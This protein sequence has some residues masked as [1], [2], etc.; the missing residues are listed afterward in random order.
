[1]KKIAI[2]LL[3]GLVSMS[4]WSACTY[5]FDATQ[6]QITAHETGLLKFPNMIG[7]QVTFNISPT[8]STGNLNEQ[9]LYYTTNSDVLVNNNFN[10]MTPPSAGIFA[11]EYKFKVPIE[12]MANNEQIVFFPILSGSRTS[13]G[14]IQGNISAYFNSSNSA[15][16]RILNAFIIG[17]Q[18]A[19]T[20]V[21]MPVTNTSDGYQRIGVYINQTTKQVGYIL[22][23]INKGYLNSY[24]QSLQGYYFEIAAG[25]IGFTSSSPNLGKEIS[26]ELI[27]D[28]SK[29]TQTYPSGTKDMCG[30]AI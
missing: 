8:T 10:I 13:S 9:K 23:G 22:N 6:A 16:N 12:Q 25:I 11:F 14:L 1:M 26:I 4:G 7:Q 3:T 29:F 17:D 15:A 18:N 21:E 20:L 2:G 30:T 27:T 19:Q 24:S 28:H 5:N